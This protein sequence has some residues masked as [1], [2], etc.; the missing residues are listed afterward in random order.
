MCVCI[1]VACVCSFIYVCLHILFVSLSTL[2]LMQTIG[3]SRRLWISSALSPFLH[4]LAKVVCNV[5]N[6]SCC[7]SLPLFLLFVYNLSF[8]MARPD[9]QFQLHEEDYADGHFSTSLKLATIA[10]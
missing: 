9:D 5:N 1:F 6:K 3:S 7:H 2:A 10:N 4:K 8:A